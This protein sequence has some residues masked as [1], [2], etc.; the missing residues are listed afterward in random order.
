MNGGSK[1][2]ICNLRMREIACEDAVQRAVCGA[3]LPWRRSLAGAIRRR[4]RYCFG[5][6]G[7]TA[8]YHYCVVDLPRD[9]SFF[10]CFLFATQSCSG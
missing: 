8:Y 3:G 9:P 6:I 1:F 4:R 5:D 2:N 10:S 7:G